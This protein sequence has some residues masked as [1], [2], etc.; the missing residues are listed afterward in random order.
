MRVFLGSMLEIERY[1]V[2][3]VYKTLACVMERL[4]LAGYIHLGEGMGDFFFDTGS[5][6]NLVARNLI[7]H[8]LSVTVDVILGEGEVVQFNKC[9]TDKIC[10]WYISK[11]LKWGKVL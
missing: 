7:N 11:A 6:H 8:T 5:V 4:L 3:Y 2:K 10:I 9:L 1:L